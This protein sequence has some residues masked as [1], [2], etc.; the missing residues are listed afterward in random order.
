[1]NTVE[2]QPAAQDSV[3]PFCRY[4]QDYVLVLDECPGL[5][6][7]AVSGRPRCFRRFRNRVGT[8]D[9]VNGNLIEDDEIAGG[10]LS[11]PVP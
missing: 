11:A 9:P 6:R 3:N 8:T 7:Y 1:M 4:C 2:E 5:S 10:G